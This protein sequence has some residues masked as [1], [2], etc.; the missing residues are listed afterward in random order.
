MKVFGQDNTFIKE[1]TTFGIASIIEIGIPFE[2][3]EAKPCDRVD[4]S[5][6]VC[7]DGQELERWPR[8]SGISFSVPSESYA[9][10]QWYV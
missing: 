6:E 2:I 8:G 9:Q 3:I 7:K 4:F 10:E 5:V 1:L